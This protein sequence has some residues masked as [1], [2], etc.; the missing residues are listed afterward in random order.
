MNELR[1]R[2]AAFGRSAQEQVLVATKRQAAAE[3]WRAYFDALANDEALHLVRRLSET[4]QR[5]AVS[6][7]AAAE[8]RLVSGV[9]ADVA[10][11]S[12]VRIENQRI[13]AEGRARGRRP[14]WRSALGLGQADP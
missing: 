7:K 11:A 1:V 14:S 13:A 3:A 10:D 8:R 5:V 4:A 9:D 6:S 12:F 2:S